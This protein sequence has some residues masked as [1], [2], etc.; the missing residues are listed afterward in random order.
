MPA[1]VLLTTPNPKPQRRIF[2]GWYI[3]GVILLTGLFAGPTSQV[4][5]GIL[6]DPISEDTGWSATAIAGAVTV[7]GV[8]AGVG[9]PLV[10]FLAD[11]YSPRVLMT[12]GVV[13]MG[14]SFFLIAAAPGVWVLMA[15]YAIARGI[16]QNM[17]AGVVPRVVAVNWFRRMRGRAI[18][19]VGTAHPI[20]TFVLGPVALL[21][22]SA[23]Y[24]WRSVW[25]VLGIAV[26]VFLVLPNALIIRRTPE[27][28]G[29]LPDG[30]D[31]TEA[32]GQAAVEASAR[33]AAQSWTFREAMRTPSFVLILIAIVLTNYGGGGLPFHMPQYYGQEGFAVQIGVAAVS[34]FAI[35]GAFANT[36]WGFLAERISERLLGIFTMLMG[37]ALAL[38]FQ[39]VSNPVVAVAYGVLLGVASRGEGSIL[40]I[41]IANYYGR[42]SYGAISGVVQTALLVGLALGPLIMSMVRESTGSYLPVF[43]SAAVTF[44]IAAVLLA[45]AVKPKRPQHAP[46]AAINAE[47]DSQP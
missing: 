43:Y 18:G 9:S 8:L 10:G 38:G 13:L 34:M 32:G 6:V 17:I 7:G 3:L 20:G 16:A 36:L 46:N 11:R 25:V 42:R 1:S 44:T 31:V 27:E 30:D 5:I 24:N 12:L 28:M 39:F 37:T 41:L 40:M 2:Y 35:S 19:L 14:A 47:G 22:I 33:E 23:G 26:I 45:L 21:I 4:F 15:G 29:L